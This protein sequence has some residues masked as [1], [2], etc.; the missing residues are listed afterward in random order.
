MEGKEEEEDEDD[1]GCKVSSFQ[2]PPSVNQ[3][4]ITRAMVLIS[5]C[6]L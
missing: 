4:K 6:A 1:K 2:A 3:S 5:N